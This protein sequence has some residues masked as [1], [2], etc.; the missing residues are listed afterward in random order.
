M[1]KQ[2]FPL[3]HQNRF[4]LL[5]CGMAAV[6]MLIVYFCTQM[7]PIGDNSILRMD[8]YH[9]Y[10]PLFAELYDRLFSHGSLTYSWT[11]GLGSCFLGN[12]FN[13]LS[14]P[15]GAIVVFFGHKHVP[16]AIAAMILIKAGLSAGTFTWYLKRSVRS[17]SLLSAT[18]GLLYAFCAYMLAYYW[19]VMWL[20]AMVL[21]PVILY[22]IERIINEGKIGVYLAALALS[23]FSNYYMSY[24]LCIFSVLYFVYYY[25][26]HYSF[27]SLVNR[28]WGEKHKSF[29]G[30][31]KN[32]RLLRAGVLFA[33]AS[34]AAAGLMACVL[35][36]TY[37]ILQNCSAT[38]GSFP[39][40]VKS[41]FTIFDFFANHFTALTTTIRSSGDDVLP[42]VYCGVLTLILAPL[43]FFT[44][45]ISKK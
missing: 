33:L 39:Q 11:S 4:V 44:K 37:R 26:A 9:Q 25:F 12:Y 35:I 7:F 38:N 18:F 13:Y 34:L 2:R 41:Y 31:C 16:E 21:L 3:L 14:S 15:I 28:R 29:V 23:M 17:H 40:E 45:S 22:G 8:L 30:S 10:G 36:P 20:D 19:N 5:S 43:Y 1:K 6:A 24:M 32:S 27:S 42:N